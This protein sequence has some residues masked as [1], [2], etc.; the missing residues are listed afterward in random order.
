MIDG[1]YKYFIAIIMV[2]ISHVTNR[3]DICVWL[4]LIIPVFHTTWQKK[5]FP[6]L[7]VHSLQQPRTMNELFIYLNFSVKTG[8]AIYLFVTFQ[9]KTCLFSYFLQWLNYKCFLWQTSIQRGVVLWWINKII[10]NNFNY[11]IGKTDFDCL[12]LLWFTECKIY[13]IGKI[14]LEGD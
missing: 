11:L 10:I 4:G 2:Y 3:Y 1:V 6:K 9:V 5:Y 14:R 7:L 13:F 12:W 8:P